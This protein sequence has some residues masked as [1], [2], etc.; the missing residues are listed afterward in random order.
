MRQ[1]K[2]IKGCKCRIEEEEEEEEEEVNPELMAVNFSWL[3]KQRELLTLYKLNFI[4]DISN[5]FL[6]LKALYKGFWIFTRRHF[7]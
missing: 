1:L 6:T 2:L 5:A 3:M 4:I 7:L